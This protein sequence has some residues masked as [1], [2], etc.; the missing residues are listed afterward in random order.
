MT[1]AAELE[2]L[3]VEQ[4]K[5]E[6]RYREPGRRYHDLAHVQQVLGVVDHLAPVAA[7]AAA[8]R[9][10]AWFHDAVYEPTRDDNERRSADLAAET[11]LALGADHAL[12]QEV[13]R[14]VLVTEDHVV[15]ADDRNAIVLSD[16][17]LS[18]LGADPK[19]YDAYAAAVRAEYAHL[20]DDTFA[21]GRIQ[22][23]RSVAERE[24]IYASHWGREHLEGPARANLAREQ[25]SLAASLT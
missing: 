3:A 7:D 14:L 17:D 1:T 25:E 15:D 12:V 19:R 23:L 16:A 21:R 20:S 24:S 10:A 8:V 5:L 22:V 9:L 4:A 2:R 6:R 18:I 11:L 13:A